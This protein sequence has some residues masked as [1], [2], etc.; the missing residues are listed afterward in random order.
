MGLKRGESANRPYLPVG[1]VDR[2][3][4]V[5]EGARPDLPH[6][7]VFA[8][9][10]ELGL[11]AAATR[12][13]EGRLRGSKGERGLYGRPRGGERDRGGKRGEGKGDRTR[14]PG[15][16]CS[17]PAGPLGRAP[18]FQSCVPLSCRAALGALQKDEKRGPRYYR[19]RE[20]ER[21]R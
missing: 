15:P 2:Q 3:I 21:A 9:D 12:H 20:G 10:N 6:Q 17:A 13:G 1:D 8:S 19:G 16:R 7:L 18:P 11:G 5:P 14:K 4:D